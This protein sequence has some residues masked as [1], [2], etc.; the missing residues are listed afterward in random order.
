MIPGQLLEVVGCPERPSLRPDPRRPLRGAPA[1]RAPRAPPSAPAAADPA[2]PADPL[3]GYRALAASFRRHLLAENKRPRT[4]ET[5]G[6]GVRLLGE[7]L[8]AERLPTD[9]ARLRREHVEAFVAALLARCET[10]LWSPAGE[11]ARTYLRERG[12]RDATLR[13]WRIGWSPRERRVPAAEWGLPA[14][15]RPV[16]LPRGIVLPWLLAGEPWELRVPPEACAAGRLRPGRQR[17]GPSRS[18]GRARLTAAGTGSGGRAAAVPG[19]RGAGVYGRASPV[20]SWWW[21]P[22]A[23]SVTEP[24][25]PTNAATYTH[26]FAA[27][28]TTT[29]ASVLERDAGVTGCR[30]RA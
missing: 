19:R 25:R 3:S 1:P 8:V 9:V 4:V 24:C 29:Q 18:V 30:R 2:D 16:W 5:Y 20:S 10:A 28:Q 17:P 14:A 27:G 13:A 12:L 21:P 6:E 11:R 22:T 15:E 7:F 23:R 26:T